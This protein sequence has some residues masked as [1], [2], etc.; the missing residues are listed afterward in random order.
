MG[1]AC[2][3][4]DYHQ[5]SDLMAS[6][7]YIADPMCSWCYGFGPELR[8]LQEGLPGMQINIVVGG[9]RAYNTKP[10]DEE[11]KATLLSHWQHVAEKTG[12]P[13]SH[14]ALSR[15]D[16]LYDTEPACRAVVTARTLA[17]ASALAVFD[18]IQHAFY[19]EGRDVTQA[20]VLAAVASTALNA[21][22]CAVDTASFLANWNSAA[23][24]D[25]THQDFVQARHWGISGFPTL[26]LERDGQLD[27]VTSGYVSVPVLVD[28]LQQLVDR[29]PVIE[30]SK[31]S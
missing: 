20:D 14:D 7:M 21:A 15:E 18:A 13:F 10:M 8:A 29:E 12:L 17:P 1:A 2:F 30:A 16:F 26:V 31:T 4:N 23:M 3:L 9:L 24:R 27:L 28:L 6:L 19:V 11:L 25:A 22:G 5:E